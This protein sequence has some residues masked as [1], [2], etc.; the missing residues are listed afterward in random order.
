MS[1]GDGDIEELRIAIATQLNAVEYIPISLLL[2]L[3]LEYNSA[4]FW[5]LHALGIAF[6]SG[7]A[8]HAYGLINTRIKLR[9]LGMQITLYTLV[10]LAIFNLIFL[11]Y[12]Q[13]FSLLH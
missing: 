3:A 12:G 4:S 9:V 8:I 1:L 6:I 13:I 10:A 7:R 2:L 11:P 5:L